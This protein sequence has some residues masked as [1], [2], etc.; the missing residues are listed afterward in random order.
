MIRP[1]Q[2]FIIATIITGLLAIT[3]V[4]MSE[5]S[6]CNYKVTTLRDS[7]FYVNQYVVRFDFVEVRDNTGHWKLIRSNE[8]KKIEYGN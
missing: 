7:V 6:K 1:L 5:N 3:M 8:I 2:V 4:F